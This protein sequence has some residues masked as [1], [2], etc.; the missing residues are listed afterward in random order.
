M[1]K[2]KS[3]SAQKDEN[4]FIA[5]KLGEVADLLEQQ[6]ASPFRARAYRDAAAYVAALANPIA[7]TYRQKGRS[8]LEALP[9]IGT[10]IAAAVA[11][12]IET[13]ALGVIDRLRGAAD[14]ERLLQTVPMIGPALAHQIHETLHIDTL[15]AL[16]AAA[17]NGRLADMKGIGRRRTDSIRH[18]LNDMLARRRPRQSQSNSAPPPVADILSVDQTYRETLDTLPTI[19]P[20]R[21]N[22]TGRFRIPILHTERGPWHF[23]ALFSNTPT[24]HRFGRTHDW[25]VIYHERDGHP[26]GQSTVVTQHGGPLDGRRV[27]RGREKSCAAFYRI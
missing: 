8:G 18:S 6:N 24:A 19:N 25:V 26:D 3:R 4:L 7:A 23:T 15:E 27:I 13:G 9:T 14:P 17:L 22:E 2:R 5:E 20:R 10:S 12:L 21:F 1:A 11:E 16:E